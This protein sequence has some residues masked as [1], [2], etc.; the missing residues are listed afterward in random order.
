MIKITE[1]KGEKGFFKKVY[2]ENYY[3][4]FNFKLKFE[5]ES[6]NC[7]INETIIVYCNTD[8]MSIEVWIDEPNIENYKFIVET[9]KIERL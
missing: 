3:G 5:E 8:Q 1:L 4:T 2:A 7:D 9:Y 6:K